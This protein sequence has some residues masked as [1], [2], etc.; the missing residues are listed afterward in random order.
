MMPMLEKLVARPNS[1][2]RVKTASG[3]A[4]DGVFVTTAKQLDSICKSSRDGAAN[5]RMWLVTEATCER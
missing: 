5:W 3:T 1:L 4:R 2:R